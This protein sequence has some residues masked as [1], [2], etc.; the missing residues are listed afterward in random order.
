[1][2]LWARYI[3][4]SY[5]VPRVGGFRLGIGLLALVFLL[6]AELI[7]GVVLYERGVQEWIWETDPWAGG[8]GAVV[9]SLFG[10]LPLLLM[11]V[12]KKSDEVGKVV[13][14]HG[15]EKKGLVDAV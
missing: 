7:S 15:H 5:E 3:T 8:A 10:L 13:T 11:G 2:T 12:E 6:T 9:L 1:M 4:V 14:S